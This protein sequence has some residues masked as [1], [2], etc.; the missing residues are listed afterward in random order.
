[1]THTLL[2]NKQAM[3]VFLLDLSQGKEKYIVFKFLQM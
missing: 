1:M 2:L 3:I